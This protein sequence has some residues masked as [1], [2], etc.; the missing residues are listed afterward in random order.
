MGMEKWDFRGSHENLMGMGMNLQW[1]WEWERN[2]S[3]LNGMEIH[4]K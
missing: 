3:G 1:E 2:R 4:E